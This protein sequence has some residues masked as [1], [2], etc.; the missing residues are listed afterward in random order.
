MSTTGKVRTVLGDIDAAD[1]GRVDSHDHLIIN[2]GPGTV[3]T[4]DLL[5]DDVD[6]AVREAEE[7]RAAGGGT[8]VDMMPPGAGRSVA[9]LTEIARR[10]GVHIIAVT[11]FHKPEY[12]DK[13]H[14]AR[15]GD[16]ETLVKVLLDDCKGADRW[17]YWRPFGERLSARPGLIKWA[18][19]Y[20]SITAAHQVTLRAIARVSLETGLPIIT[21]T[22]HG[23]AA[24]RQLDLLEACG[25]P[26]DRVALSHMDRNPDL[27]LH[28]AL[29]DRGCFLVYDGAGREKY[30]PV[31]AI[32]ALLGA[33]VEAGHGDRI[34][35]GGDLAMRAER[36]SR[37]GIGIRGVLT[38][39]AAGLQRN[40]VA[41]ETIDRCLVDNPRSYLRMRN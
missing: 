15:C 38:E 3:R 18:T 40:G 33:M 19:N 30:H 24:L 23:T 34:L 8:I 12:Y 7:F 32:A 13:L 36:L 20:N 9:A 25:V 41:R 5:L 4:P 37:G 26:P 11:G 28:K 27:G 39:F 22:E 16:E 29:A 14:W 35:L 31:S 10:S 1:L 2:G 17:D 6:D 21:H